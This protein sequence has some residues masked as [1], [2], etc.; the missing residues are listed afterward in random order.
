MDAT[1]LQDYSPFQLR[2]LL[3]RLRE[4]LYDPLAVRLLT[5]DHAALD[6]RLQQTLWPQATTPE[7]ICVSAA[8]MARGNPIPWRISRRRRCSRAM[9]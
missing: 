4:G 1:A 5:A 9:S 2:R 7:P 6:A 8:A 3:E